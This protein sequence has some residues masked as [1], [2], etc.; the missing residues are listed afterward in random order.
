MKRI[1]QSVKTGVTEMVETPCPQN[2]PGHLLIQ[3]SHSLISPGTEKM[4]IEFSKASLL[5]KMRQ[6]PD[7]VRVVFEKIKTDG[8]F[9]TLDVVRDK[10]DQALALGYSN[11]GKVIEVGKGVND[12]SIGDRVISNGPHAEV[13]CVPKNLCCRIP[14]GVS[15]ETAAFTVLGAIGLQGI[16]L[17]APTLG[18]S[19]VVI[20]LGLIGL[21]AIQLLRAHGCRVLG[22]DF[23]KNKLNLASQFGAEIVDLSLGEDP[24]AKA[25]QFSHSRGV[26][27]VLITASTRSNDPVHQAATM[28]RKRGRIV[29][30]GVTGLAL[31]RADFYE[32]ELSFQVSCSYGPG[33]YDINY[34]EGGH[35]YP[36]GFVR[37]TEQ[38][39][40]EAF[41]DM[42]QS[43]RISVDAL[44]TKRFCFNDALLAYQLLM[45][46]KHI[47]GLILEYPAKQKDL[48]KLKTNLILINNA[49]ASSSLPCIGFIGAGNYASRSLIPAF[50]NT[51]ATLKMIACSGGISGTKMGK[52]HGFEQVTTDT[53]HIF[54]DPKINAIVIATRHHHHAHFVCESLKSNKHVFV[55]KPLCVSLPELYE[56]VELQSQYPTL[57]IMVGFNRRFSPHVIKIKSLLN[58]IHEPKS[59]IMTVNAGE[60]PSSHWTQN[61]EIGGGRI[62]GEV[63]HFIDLLRFL[64]G[65]SI[66]Q[67]Q[68][69]KMGNISDHDK[70]SLALSFA[71]G[72]FGI[73]HYL[74]NGHPSFP[75]ERLEIFASG[76]ILQLD[77]FRELKGYGWPAFKKLK[78]WRQD[79]GQK[80]CVKQFVNALSK[81]IPF[82]IAMEELIEV[83]R[84]TL[85][86][87]DAARF[88][89]SPD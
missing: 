14:A 73:I 6:Q 35:D 32:K 81:N 40:F 38:R 75:K 39:N 82:P 79:K 1:L 29:L 67:Y 23:D 44:I 30:V 19:F 12:F 25:R 87:A 51:N 47:L 41:L 33:R 62:I 7:K 48:K 78:L 13:V 46:D 55:E 72:S 86:I 57:Q 21:I 83:S 43:Q 59:L 49:S 52:K 65:A 9:Q 88:Y 50:K 28:S 37:W 27:G 64:V 85:E 56:I 63:C 68:L 20:G 31:S 8:L 15:N 10:L 16:R 36:I 58:S 3:T 17:A 84:I 89:P 74:A 45:E 53:K 42:L 18:E 2:K 24:V 5:E 11:V 77:N 4:L 69:T 60:I 66:T 34:E 80:N 22:I 54:S 70:I 61:Q 71:D 26:D 76:K